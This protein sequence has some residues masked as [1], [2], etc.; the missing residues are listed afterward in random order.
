[1]VRNKKNINKGVKLYNKILREFTKV[2]DN[3]P[4][5]RK[6]TLAERRKYVSERIYP[7][8]KGAS[9]SRVGVKAINV[10]VFQLLET[11]VPKEGCDVN[12]I[13]PSVTA[14]VSW[15]EI[16]DFIRDVLPP[17]IYIRVDAG[18]LGTTKIFNT[19][20]Y[21]F[22]KSGVSKIYDN[23]RDEVNNN[24]DAS[25]EGVKKLRKGKAN[26]GTP[27]NYFI[28]FVLVIGTTPI[29]ENIPVVYNLPK[30]EKKKVTSVKNAIASRIKDLNNKKKRRKN[31]RKNAIKNIKE[32]RKIKVRQSKAKSPNYKLKLAEKKIKGYNKTIK[33]LQTALNRGNM[34][35]EQ[36][37]KFEQELIKLITDAMRE[38]GIV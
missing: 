14:D 11:I 28:D 17:C 24:S 27:E 35:Q 26:D 13:S 16:D 33:Q 10:S 22:V 2:N 31:A 30:V 23:I 1:M 3:L 7:Q 4:E 12:Y 9:A 37:D 8:Y 20:N 6:L 18:S 32:V 36:F 5:D 15:F 38:G 19:S 25:F 34:T 21:D 29:K